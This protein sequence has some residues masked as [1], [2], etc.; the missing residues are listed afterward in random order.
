MHKK[1]TYLADA[2][3]DQ[4]FRTGHVNE[5]AVRWQQGRTPGAL[6]G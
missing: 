3:T 5:T 2:S 4:F 1:P 6:H